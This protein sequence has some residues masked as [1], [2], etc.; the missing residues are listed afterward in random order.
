MK[1]VL[2]NNT[3][4]IV[5]ITIAFIYIILHINPSSD[6]KTTNSDVSIYVKTLDSGPTKQELE[7]RFKQR[8]QFYQQQC[9]D[10]RKSK[11][12]KP[13]IT[14]ANQKY[15]FAAC[16]PLKTGCSTWFA[17]FYNLE[18]PNLQAPEKL[19]DIMMEKKTKTSWELKGEQRK[20]VKGVEDYF[21]TMMISRHPLTRLYSG[22]HEHMALDAET[23]K[24]F[25]SQFKYFGLKESDWDMETRHRKGVK[26]AKNVSV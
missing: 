16:L 11:N 26:L 5:L 10:R 1:V 9:A 19:W 15:K 25:G 6:N 13:K 7:E 4:Y 24:P 22:W 18:Y 14:L 2:H 17:I 21:T 23:G 20:S 12:A 8:N 3:F